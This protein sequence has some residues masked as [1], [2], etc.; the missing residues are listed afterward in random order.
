MGAGALAALG[1]AD[2]ATTFFPDRPLAGPVAGRVASGADRFA[3]TSLGRLFDAAA[4]LLGVRAVQ[5]YEGQ[6][7]MELEA[8]V[9]APAAL[10][11]GFTLEDGVLSFSPLLAHFALA[12][13]DARTGASLF[14]GTLV[15]GLAALAR[16]G[17]AV[18]GLTSIA[19]GGGCLMNRVLAEG[20]SAALVTSKLTP[21]L[22]RRLPAND[23]GLSFGQAVLARRAFSET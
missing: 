3:T 9:D 20:L 8:L 23:G 11:G 16:H 10:A 18:A 21:L 6:A 22:A 7:A 14:H 17:A 4:A 1:R 13:P 12:R 5:D 19:L 2:L 15:E